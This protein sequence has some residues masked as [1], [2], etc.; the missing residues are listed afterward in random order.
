MKD[1]LKEKLQNYLTP[2]YLKSKALDFLNL[3]E[4]EGFKI[5]NFTLCIFDDFESIELTVDSRP[6]DILGIKKDKV[7]Y[8]S[9]NLNDTHKKLQNL[10]DIFN[11]T[12]Q[13]NN[14][15]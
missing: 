11:E 9:F 12:K 14:A 3:L 4:N 7:H 15:R 2:S 10:V 5:K 1:N 13:D 8:I 6:F